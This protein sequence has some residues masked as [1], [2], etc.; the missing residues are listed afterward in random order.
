MSQ[1]YNFCFQVFRIG[2][3]I[4]EQLYYAIVLSFSFTH[5]AKLKRIERICFPLIM[6]YL[7]LAS[8]EM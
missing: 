4:A 5:R 3:H 6:I 2:W 1:R 7:L 8:Y